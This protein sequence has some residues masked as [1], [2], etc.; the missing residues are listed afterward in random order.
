MKKLNL[1]AIAF[2]LL[3]WGVFGQTSDSS[4][5]ETKATEYTI[6]GKTWK[7]IQYT[8]GTK[9][10]E[11]EIDEH[12]YT[13][14]HS[15]GKSSKFHYNFLESEVG[16]NI[17][18]VDEGAPKVKPWGSWY[19]A[20]QSEGTWKASRNF[21]LKS[22]LG[23]NWY[24]FKFEDPSLVAVK[25]PDGIDWVDYTEIIT[26]PNAVPVKS[27]I[28]ASYANFTLMPTLRTNNGKMRIG[29][30]GYVGYRLGGR[31]K[32]VYE[33]E[34]DKRKD[35]TKSNMYI[36]N[37][38]YGARG[39]IGIGDVT[40]FINYDLNNLFEEQKGPEFQ[41]MSFGVRID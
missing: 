14:Y 9:S 1:T 16:I 38:R 27:K 21:H 35:F 36:A 28:S 30:G 20:L 11:W 12:D 4:K 33:V 6:F 41:A 18:P 25:T 3:S 32:F 15:E 37:F 29:A 13:N 34:G 5:V 2:L 39:E 40:L 23:V 8:D 19:V 7:V 24:N 10:Y 26:E 17:W 22:Y 31:G